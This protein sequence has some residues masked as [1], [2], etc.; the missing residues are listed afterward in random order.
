MTLTDKQKSKIVQGFIDYKVKKGYTG[1]IIIQTMP[2][3]GVWLGNDFYLEET[4]LKPFYNELKG[5]K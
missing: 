5:I 2:Q 3:K 1:K 4:I